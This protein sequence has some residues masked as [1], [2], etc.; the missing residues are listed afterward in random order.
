[1]ADGTPEDPSTPAQEGGPRW[2]G[3]GPGQCRLLAQQLPKTKNLPL[4][5]A[6]PHHFLLQED[7]LATPK[8]RNL[9]SS[10]PGPSFLGPTWICPFPPCRGVSFYL[11]KDGLRCGPSA[12]STQARPVPNQEYW[13]K[14]QGQD[15][16]QRGER[17]GPGVGPTGQYSWRGSSH[18]SLGQFSSHGAL[19]I[20][21]ICMFKTSKKRPLLDSHHLILETKDQNWEAREGA[22]DGHGSRGRLLGKATSQPPSPVSAS[23]RR[24]WD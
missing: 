6:Q 1:M 8:G 10:K 11:E 7:L 2:T 5:S 19:G 9:L 13:E 23:P 12:L 14:G 17:K 21:R 24:E 22:A 18:W 16:W 3:L 4:L 20:H 15:L